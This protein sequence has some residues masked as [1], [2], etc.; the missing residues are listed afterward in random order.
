[1]ATL[2]H[3]GAKKAQTGYDIE[4]PVMAYERSLGTRPVGMQA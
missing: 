3:L 2:P 1:M 4:P